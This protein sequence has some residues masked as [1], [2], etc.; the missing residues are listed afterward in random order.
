M[1]HFLEAW[2]VIDVV[3]VVAWVAGM[4]YCK[5]QHTEAEWNGTV[6]RETSEI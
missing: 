6:S 4:A 5:S 1:W 3:L 2:A